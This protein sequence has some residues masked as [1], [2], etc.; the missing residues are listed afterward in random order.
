MTGRLPPGA[1]APDATITRSVFGCGGA[2][3]VGHCTDR[4]MIGCGGSTPQA[5]FL[6]R[7]RFRKATKKASIV[8]AE[9]SAIFEL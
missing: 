7:D 8:S 2:G 6:G 9:R 1:M 5:V 3:K 4:M